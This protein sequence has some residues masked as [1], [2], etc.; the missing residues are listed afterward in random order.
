MSSSE[1]CNPLFA[2]LGVNAYIDACHN[3]SSMDPTPSSYIDLLRRISTVTPRPFSM[4]AENI[5]PRSSQSPIQVP[6]LSLP[7]PDD[8]TSSLI[9]AG[10]SPSLAARLSDAFYRSANQIRAMYQATH[11]QNVARQLAT[12]P[13]LQSS[14][15]SLLPAIERQYR[16]EIH[17]LEQMTFNRVCRLKPAEPA[18]SP[19]KSKP[20]FNQVREDRKSVV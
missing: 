10:A 13:C 19:P 2:Q 16:E 3:T 20:V 6:N 9:N 12:D 15:S 11:H 14:I 17:T 8:I 4:A 1:L 18:N 5:Q 7:L